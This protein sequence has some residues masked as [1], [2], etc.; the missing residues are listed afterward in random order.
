MQLIRP[1]KVAEMLSVSQSTLE[2]WRA[3][4][5][6]PP[7]VKVEGRIRYDLDRVREYVRTREATP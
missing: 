2:A 1:A 6:G 4:G 7:W 3:A 5:K